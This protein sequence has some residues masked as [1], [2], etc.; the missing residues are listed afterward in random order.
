MIQKTRGIVFRFTRY[1]ETSIVVTIFTES[2]GLQSYIVNG[3][4]SKSSK[5][6]MALFQPL[7]LL[8]LVVYHR[9]RA[10]LERIKEVQCFHPY[11]TLTTDIRKSSIGMFIIEV[12]NKCIRDEMHGTEIFEYIT[13][14][15]VYL[16]QTPDRFENFH[17]IFLLRLSRFL[18][19]GAYQANDITGGFMATPELSIIIDQLLQA[20]HDTELQITGA[21]RREILDMLLLFYAHHLEIGELKSLAV[22]RTILS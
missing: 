8:N 18:G 2:F 22:L 6:K 4:R 7:T 17:L 9:E 16:D 5:N 1:G 21:Q 14:A 19:F 10:N 12:L 20:N 15:L 3:V 11:H 13:N